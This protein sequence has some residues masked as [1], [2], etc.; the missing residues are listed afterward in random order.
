VATIVV[1]AHKRCSVTFAITAAS[2]LEAE[3]AIAE[4]LR[5]DKEL[6]WE[7]DPEGINVDVIWGNNIWRPRRRFLLIDDESRQML[8]EN[9]SDARPDGEGE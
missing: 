1:K 9:K 5:S 2:R 3:A 6:V 8:I 4:K 7:D